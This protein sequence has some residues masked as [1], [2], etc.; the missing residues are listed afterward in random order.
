MV[1]KVNNVRWLRVIMEEGAILGKVVKKGLFERCDILIESWILR[2]QP[3]KCLKE[4]I[5]GNVNS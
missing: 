5:T 4:N 2:N 3:Y 1:Q